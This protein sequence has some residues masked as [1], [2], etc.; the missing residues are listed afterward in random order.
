MSYTFLDSTTTP[1]SH[2]QG[3]TKNVF[4][5][6]GVYTQNCQD[7]ILAGDSVTRKPN[8]VKQSNVNFAGSQNGKIKKYRIK[9]FVEMIYFNR[10]HRIVFLHP[11]LW[12]HSVIYY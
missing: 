9:K 6:H 5:L 7:D 4:Y 3:R 12:Q 11:S 2:T 8:P 10:L 1:R